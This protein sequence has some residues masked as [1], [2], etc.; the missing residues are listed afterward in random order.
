MLFEVKVAYK[1]YTLKGVRQSTKIDL[2][3]EWKDA[4]ALL[5]YGTEIEQVGNKL[6]H[7]TKPS[8]NYSATEYCLIELH[9]FAECGKRHGL[10][11]WPLRTL[12]FVLHSDGWHVNDF[13]PYRAASPWWLNHFFN[14]SNVRLAND[15]QWPSPRIQQLVFATRLRQGNCRSLRLGSHFHHVPPNLPI[16]K[17]LHQPGRAEVDCPHSFHCP[18]LC[19]RVMAQP[20]VLRRKLLLC[21]LQRNQGLLWR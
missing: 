8:G 17:I 13:V 11:N 5:A 4:C 20:H 3:S 16:F 9:F 7:S 10:S 1:V 14:S 21:L 15:L 18:H 2:I 12:R 6:R 19:F